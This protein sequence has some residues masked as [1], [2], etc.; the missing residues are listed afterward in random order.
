[1]ESVKTNNQ[2]VSLI[3]YEVGG[4]ILVQKGDLLEECGKPSA[5]GRL[6]LK[7][8]GDVLPGPTVY[9]R[10]EDVRSIGDE[11]EVT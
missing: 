11:S 7:L 9:L 10:R 6:A 1:M 2:C 4:M 8:A 3:T 5:D